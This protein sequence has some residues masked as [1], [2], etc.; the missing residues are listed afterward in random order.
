MKAAFLAVA[1]LLLL[2]AAAPARTLDLPT[3]FED[4]LPQVKEQTE[5]PV[6]LPQVEDDVLY[7]IQAHAGTKNR[8]RSGCVRWRTAP[9]AT[10]LADLNVPGRE[11]ITWSVRFLFATLIAFL[12]SVSPA[13]ASVGPCKPG[14]SPDGP[15]CTFWKGKVTLVADGDTIDVD[16][17]GDGRRPRGGSG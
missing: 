6:L 16:I 1:F 7:W 9:S 14:G 13:S 4:V 10:G 17:A 3:L 12:V 5:V 8:R 15:L 11:P 2:P